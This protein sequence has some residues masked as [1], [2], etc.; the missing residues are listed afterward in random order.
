[1]STNKNV[2]NQKCQHSKMSTFKNIYYQKCQHLKMST[3]IST[4]IPPL[5]PLQGVECVCL[6]STH[7]IDPGIS[8]V[9]RSAFP[10]LIK[11]TNH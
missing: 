7:N 9:A 10:K 3:N 8:G 6:P 2:N 11:L 5:S 4:N 1:M